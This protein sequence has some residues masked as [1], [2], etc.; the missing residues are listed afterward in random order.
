MFL[1]SP[2]SVQVSKVLRLLNGGKTEHLNGGW[3]RPPSRRI[4]MISCFYSIDFPRCMLGFV[5]FDSW[6]FWLVDWP[7]KHTSRNSVSVCELLQPW[8]VTHTVLSYRNVCL[9]HL[10]P[11]ETQNTHRVQQDNKSDFDFNAPQLSWFDRIKN[12]FLLSLSC[13]VSSFHHMNKKQ[14]SEST[15]TS[16]DLQISQ[17]TH[18]NFVSIKHHN[19]EVWTVYIRMIYHTV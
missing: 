2:A 9:Q 18:F 4:F 8:H 3:A 5:L 16:S 17:I 19:C 1:N 10:H 7:D 14:A 12:I 15:S 13:R 6:R 11:N